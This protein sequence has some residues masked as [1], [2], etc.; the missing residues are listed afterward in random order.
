MKEKENEVLEEKKNFESEV[1]YDGFHKIEKI[2][3]KSE[4]KEISGEVFK[5]GSTVAGLV[6]D[7]EKKK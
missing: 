2:T 7:S 1:V 3:R 6:Y 4:E 5:K